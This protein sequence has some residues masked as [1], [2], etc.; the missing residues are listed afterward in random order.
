MRKLLAAVGA[1]VLAASTAS[2]GLGT[3]GGYSP[4]GEL[5]GPLADVD[6]S[7]ASIPVGSKNFTEQLILGKM[8]VELLQSAGA[9]VQDLTNIPGSNSSREALLKGDITVA[10]EY[11]GTAWISYLGHDDPIPDEQEQF[12][13]VRVED[14]E[15]GL[16]WLDPAPMNNTYAFATPRHTAEQLGISK[17]SDLRNLSDQQRSYC[18]DSEFANR[19]DG[20]QP[21]LQTYDLP[22][23]SQAQVSTLDSGSIY[24]ATANGTCNFGEVFATD[25]RII[26]LD[27]TVLEDDLAFFPKYNVTTVVHHSV[28]EQYPQIAELFA[29]VIAE[30]T[31]E[32][33]QRLNAQV[34]VD[35]EEPADVAW[36]WLEEQGFVSN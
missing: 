25:G 10:W 13:A 28:Y 20:F 1:L 21:M 9:K 30:L 35:G 36:Q 34:D 16:V 23:P 6:M 24:A 14:A 11:T 15:N 8:A 26:A 19:N 2:C 29:P 12:E 5:A 18:V 7:G 22:A 4:S 3:A 27:L 32:T 31:D 33:M 17:L